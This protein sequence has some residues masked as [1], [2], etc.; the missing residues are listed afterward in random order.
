M[1]QVHPNAARH[2]F[3]ELILGHDQ[4]DH[5]W[6]QTSRFSRDFPHLFTQGRGYYSL[7]NAQGDHHTNDETGKSIVLA[8]KRGI[9]LGAFAKQ[10]V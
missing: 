1:E 5:I 7:V 3:E 6:Q 8:N 10:A 4:S 2:S 9:T